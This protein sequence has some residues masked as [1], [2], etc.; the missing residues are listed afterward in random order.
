VLSLIELDEALERGAKAIALI[1]RRI[2]DRAPQELV[3]ALDRRFAGLSVWRRWLSAGWHRA[4]RQVCQQ[5]AAET[6][7]RMFSALMDGYQLIC[8][9]LERTLAEHQIRRLECVGRAV[10]PSTMTVVELTDDPQAAPETVVAELRPGYTW[11][12][13]VI[14]FAEVR[15][16]RNERSQEQSHPGAEE[17]IGL[18]HFERQTPWKPS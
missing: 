17:D 3:E 14:R 12:G 13:H 9:R 4:A 11:R 6:H 18:T 5:Q 8:S 2:A 10:D 7:A 1:D 16:V 15:A